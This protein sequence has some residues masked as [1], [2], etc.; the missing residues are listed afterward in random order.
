MIV[1][2]PAVGQFVAPQGGDS[3]DSYAAYC[4]VIGTDPIPRVA[5]LQGGLC[6]R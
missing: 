4:R 2:K 3:Y 5:W 6:N 1:L